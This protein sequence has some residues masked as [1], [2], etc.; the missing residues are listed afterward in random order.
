MT[1]TTADLQEME[2]RIAAFAAAHRAGTFG[3]EDEAAFTAPYGP[4]E[5]WDVLTEDRQV[6]GPHGPVPVRLYTP[7][8]AARAPRAVLVFCHGGGFMHGDLDM[9]EGDATARGV[10]GRADV[11]VVSVDY[12][13]CDELDGRPTRSI[14]GTD[15]GLVI[16]APIPGDDVI[17]VVDWT[18]SAAEELGIDPDRLALGGCSAGGNL[19]A[20]VSLRLAEAG[21]APSASLLMYLVSHPLNPEPT[22]EEAEALEF[23]PLELSFTPEKMRA[24]SENYIGRPLEEA[25]AHD[26]PGLGTPEQLAVLPRTYIEADEY[27]SLR[28]G[29]RRYSEQLAEAGVEVEYEVRRGVNH[30]HLN[31]L[32]L[33]QAAQ[34]M[35]RMAGLMKE[36]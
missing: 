35:D 4:A 30:G 31:K 12:R 2:R 9:P 15:P 36:L 34:S 10:A 23:L 22:A 33:P 5:E 32:G 28:L 3:P 19:A 27:D 14:P 13:L 26:F 29:A 6:P 25:T 18:R 24:M 7:A 1:E 17:A 20:S 16:H 21:R 11:V 8:A